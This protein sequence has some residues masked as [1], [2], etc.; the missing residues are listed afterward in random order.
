MKR[1]CPLCG[2]EKCTRKTRLVDAPVTC[3]LTLLGVP[4]LA[5]RLAG[6]IDWSWWWV[7]CPFWLPLGVGWL[8]FLF[9]V[10]MGVADALK[11]KLNAQR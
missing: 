2:S 11:E 3:V 8:V 7:T 4:L 1:R 9:C 5:L 10:A 6:V